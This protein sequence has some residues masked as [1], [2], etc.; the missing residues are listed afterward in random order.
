MNR[1][2]DIEIG[3]RD[4]HTHNGG[5]K[6]ISPLSLHIALN[7]VKNVIYLVNVLGTGSPQLLGPRLP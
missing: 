4:R 5:L 3:S 7:L 2:P 6:R 1:M